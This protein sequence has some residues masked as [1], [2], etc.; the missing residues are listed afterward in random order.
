M[1][2]TQTSTQKGYNRSTLLEILNAREATVRFRKLD[3]E[4]RTM[5]CTLN[6]QLL[7]ETIQQQWGRLNPD[8]ANQSDQLITVYDLEMDGWRSFHPESIIEVL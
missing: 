1:T 7:P 4:L 3:G 6:P 2:A 8:R 5:R